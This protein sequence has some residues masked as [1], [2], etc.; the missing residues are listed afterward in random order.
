MKI[1]EIENTSRLQLLRLVDRWLEGEGQNISFSMAHRSSLTNQLKKLINTKYETSYNVLYRATFV[2]I[3]TSK[4]EHLIPIHG[5]SSFTPDKSLAEWYY[6]NTRSNMVYRINVVPGTT[7]D[8]NK[9]QKTLSQK[10]AENLEWL[11]ITEDP[12]V[13]VFEHDSYVRIPQSDILKD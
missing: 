5:A 12:E 10:E 4:R 8:I 1:N 13:I 3:D 11:P 6:E 2:N 9:I 7:I